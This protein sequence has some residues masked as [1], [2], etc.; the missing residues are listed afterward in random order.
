MFNLNKCLV[1][2]PFLL[3]SL[4][5]NGMNMYKNF[6][7]IACCFF[8]TTLIAQKKIIPGFTGYAIPVEADSVEMFA[9]NKGLINWKN[10]Q[11]QIN[12]F[13][14]AGK[15]GKL[16]IAINLKNIRFASKIQ[17]QIA[18]KSFSVQVPKSSSYQLIPV[19]E[20]V[21]ADTGFYVINL[22]ALT[23]TKNYI[24]DIQSIELTGSLV[25]DIVVNPVPRRNA[26]S[27][28]LKYSIPNNSKVIA[29][30]NEVT[31]PTNADQLH[32]FYMACGFSRG[33][34]GIQVNAPSERR[35]IF[36][37]W[38]AGNEA[39]DRNKVPDENKVRLIA[40][41]EEVI[42]NDFGNEGTG[43]HSH[44]VYPWQV[45]L[46][47]K[48]LV[49]AL[50]DSASAY[51]IYT[52]YFFEPSS[53]SWKLVASFKAPYDGNTLQNL[54]S[55][56]E[57]FD[58]ANGQLVR[59][60]F[61]GNQ[62]IQNENGQW[63]ELLKSNFSYDATGKAGH[64]IDYGA[65]VDSARFFLWNG[66]FNM[67]TAKYGD[68]YNR[69]SNNQKPVIDFS[70]NIDAK[71][72]F[73]KDTALIHQS[74]NNKII[75]TSGSIGGVYYQ[76]LKEGLG[77]NVKNTDTVT[78][79]YIGRLLVDGTVFDQTKNIPAKFPLVKLIKGWQIGLTK[80]K[81][82]GKIKLIIPSELAYS[83]KSRS[84]AIPPNS[85]LVFDI[86]VLGIK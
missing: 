58:G 21:L 46:T 7:I 23:P 70:K 79:N 35:V 29:F 62:Y 82:G 48:F 59:K 12:Y 57:N 74:I 56:N 33:Y 2:F 28:H 17:L 31:I 25:N 5:M 50:A 30:Y 76:I 26:P 68:E 53:Q 19:G 16:K 83:I 8:S 86:E 4:V 55:F 18:G 9:E 37:V 10:P 1:F 81:V 13:F 85:V 3:L 72:Q 40:K 69:K 6:F 52:G 32:T 77:E 27:V 44:W 67:P 47:Y 24:A 66:G 42:T 36:S 84:K 43:G 63:I 73:K 11:T 61:Y 60:A 38:D 45:N 22:K 15:T 71:A 39:V 20:V 14:Y 80:C 49:T 34:L 54:Y 64:R 51:T 41:G 78:V 65:G 75:D